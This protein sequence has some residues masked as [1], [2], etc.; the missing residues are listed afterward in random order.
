[1]VHHLLP[2]TALTKR[3][4]SCR[5]RSLR[6]ARITSM[7]C[8]W[9]N[10]SS[11]LSGRGCNSGWSLSQSVRH[12]D[13]RPSFGIRSNI[14]WNHCG[15]ETHH[16]WLADIPR[17]TL[18]DVLSP[19]RCRN[20]QQSLPQLWIFFKHQLLADLIGW[21]FIK[22]GLLCMFHI[23]ICY[24]ISWYTINHWKYYHSMNESH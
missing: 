1:M 6:T 3:V 21:Y 4:T 15:I 13:S 20:C 12:C 2:S 5:S 11:I 8:T 9:V 14:P 10:S 19:P 18:E 7:R 17:P 23:I 24:A 16:L 22:I